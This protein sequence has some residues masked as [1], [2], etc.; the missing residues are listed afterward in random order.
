MKATRRVAAV[1][2]V[3]DGEPAAEH[4]VDGDRAERSVVAGCGRRSRRA[5]RAAAT[6]SSDGRVGVD[7]GD[8]DALHPLLLEQ[9]EVG[10]AR[11]SARLSLL[12]S[13]SDRSAASAASS[14]PWATS[15]KNGLA[16][17]SIT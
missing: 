11:A 4:V 7:R 5:C 8:Q 17:S 3:L 13:T 1:D 9:V 12:Q 16:A 6:A 15:V 14:M 2:E 10:A